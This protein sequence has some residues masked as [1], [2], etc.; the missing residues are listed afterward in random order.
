M[1]DLH[2]HSTASDGTKTPSELVE[3]GRDFTVLALTDHDNT[4]GIAEFLSAA[5]G[6][7]GRMRLPGVE[8]SV[9]PGEGYGKFHML[10]LGID[11]DNAPL[12]AFLARILDGRRERNERILANFARIGIEI[13]RDEIARYQHGEVL[14]R[15]HFATWLVDHGFASDRSAAFRDYLSANSPPETRCY[16]SRYRPDPGEAI[17]VIHAA[18]GVAVMAHPRFWTT[19]P[20]LLRIGLRRLKDIGLDGIEAVYAAN[21]PGESDEHLRAAR[22]LGLAVTA[23]SDFHGDNKP[24]IALGMKVENE[25]EFLAPLLAA[26]DRWRAPKAARE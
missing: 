15:P 5:G 20:V 23:G 19:D 25:Q 7:D 3:M 22:E 11:V 10:G 17:D 12:R 6:Q 8:L 14:A 13:P 26:L 2:V 21:A 4:D 9:A 16:V 24:D 18:H 1:I